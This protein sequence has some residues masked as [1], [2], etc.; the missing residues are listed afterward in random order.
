MQITKKKLKAWNACKGG[1]EYFLSK[2]KAGEAPYQEVLAALA[3]DDHVEWAKWLIG[4]AGPD[5][6]AIFNAASIS[7]IENFFFSGWI[8]VGKI[9]ISGFLLAGCGIKAGE[10]ISAGYAIEAG[11]GI[12]AGKGIKA[13]ED[14]EAGEDYGIFAGLEIPIAKWALHSSVI[15]KN[16]PLN[17]VSGSWSE[18]G[19]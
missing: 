18:V 4:K 16:K 11:Y 6:D 7:N 8:S 14:I 12:S 13:G 1:Y 19:A 9:S 3:Q 17:L 15:A 10:G 2:F 5:K